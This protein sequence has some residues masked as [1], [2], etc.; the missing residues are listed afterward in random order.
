METVI[1][2]GILD[3]QGKESW[4]ERYHLKEATVLWSQPA[5]P[6]VEN[7]VV[8]RFREAGVREVLDVPCGDGRNTVPLARAAERVRAADSST[9]ALA[10]AEARLRAQGLDN[11]EFATTDVFATG[12][13][14]GSFDGIVCWDLLGHLTRPAQAI[15]ELL[16][17]L[18][19]GGLLVGSVFATGDSTRG[20]EMRH[21][22]PGDEE[23]IYR[24]T[25]YFKFYDRAAS[26]ALA[27]QVAGAELVDLSLTRWME[28]PHE[29]YRE[30]EHEHESWVLT[31]RKL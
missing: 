28:P 14:D 13:A 8:A 3:E 9:S 15:G 16:R 11:V 19:P 22:G 18:R 26:E 4:E 31:F 2:R 5:V 20:L 25:F 30:Y 27:A 6:F 23:F 21:L 17:V 24:D 1:D 29:G 12:W 7:E 10:I